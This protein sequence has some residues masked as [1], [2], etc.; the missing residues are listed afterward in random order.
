MGWLISF[1]MLIGVGISAMFGVTVDVND[2]LIASGLF[3]I[4]GT[5]SVLKRND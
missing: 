3:A 1:I 4:A 2:A 5:I